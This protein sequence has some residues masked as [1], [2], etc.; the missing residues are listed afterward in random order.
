MTKSEVIKRLQQQ[1][2]LMGHEG[3][4][5]VE[6]VLDCIKESLMG[7]EKVQLVGL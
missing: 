4:I 5:A 3:R 7:S 1:S 6:T 2:G